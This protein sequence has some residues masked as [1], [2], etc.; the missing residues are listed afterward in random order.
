MGLTKSLFVF[1]LI[2]APLVIGLSGE[3]LLAMLVFI[4]D[5][6]FLFF[7]NHRKY[8]TEKQE[9]GFSFFLIIFAIIVLLVH[10][11]FRGYFGWSSYFDRQQYEENI[12]SSNGE[13]IFV[14]IL[15]MLIST[16]LYRKVKECQ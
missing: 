12:F 3:V 1:S 6:C 7:V 16:V 15:L 10:L 13:F 5:M 8:K 2:L 4:T 11:I 9:R 14:F